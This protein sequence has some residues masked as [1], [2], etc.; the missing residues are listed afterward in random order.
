M[1]AAP[2]STS[3]ASG[4]P[5][6]RSLMSVA[7]ALERLLAAAQPIGKTE[8]IDTFDACGR[9]LA[10][11][12]TARLDV[13]VAD[14]SQM[15][16]YAVRIAD[17]AGARAD[18]PVRLPVS[19]RIPAGHATSPLASASVARIF[20]GALIPEGAD[21]VVMQE[22][23]MA[24][25]AGSRVAFAAQPA[26]GEWVRRRGEDI[27][28]GQVILEAGTRLGPQHLGLAA[29][30]GT[31]R[32]SVIRRP[33]VSIF[34]TGDELAM[35][36]EVAIEDLKPGALYNSNRYTLRALI[37]A[38]GCEVVDLGIV[39]DTLAATR[40]ALVHAAAD[41]DCIVTSGG[42]SVGEEDHIRP[43]VAA[44]GRIDM[45]QLAIKPGKPFAFGAVGDA[46]FVGLPGNPVSG[47]VTFLVLVRPLLLRLQGMRNTAPA[48]F[49]MRADFEW[50]RPD[51][52]QEY[53]R[54]R[55]NPAGGLDLFAHQGS[56]VLTST[57][58]A[59]GLVE[60][61]PGCRI[62]KGDAVRFIPFSSLL[63]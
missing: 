26:S 56:A 39:P 48:A 11:S 59:D 60:N 61:P 6:A 19:Q 23:A 40:E 31:A 54:A 33:R 28:M 27:T 7:E 49:E 38:L 46:L 16:G 58:W 41:S 32:L 43:A 42:V 24:D 25:D 21:A 47:F 53:L 57:V 45:W 51:K 18:R 4:A 2:L 20:T 1:S 50:P 37:E 14:N 9:V 29:S 22:Q 12:L 44:E 13:P 5:R 3:P 62:G 8:E 30:I 63:S 36:G 55:I 17:L 34:S 15:D 52:R 35:P 10:A